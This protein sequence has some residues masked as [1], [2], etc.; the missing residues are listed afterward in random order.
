MFHIESLKVLNLQPSIIRA[1]LDFGRIP[2]WSIFNLEKMRS[3]YTL[4]G[5]YP[6][7]C[8]SSMTYLTFHACV[9]QPWQDILFPLH[10]WF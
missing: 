1:S 8:I 4:A 5:K 9:I 6:Q 2:E 3:L 7:M 10:L